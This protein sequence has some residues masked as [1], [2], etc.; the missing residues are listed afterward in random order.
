M[1]PILVRNA[2]DVSGPLSRISASPHARPLQQHTAYHQ[3]FVLQFLRV[4]HMLG[5]MTQLG[6]LR[7][8][9]QVLDR[10]HPRA[11]AHMPRMSG[12]SADQGLHNARGYEFVSGVVVF[13]DHVVV[14]HG[15]I[16]PM[17]EQL[18]QVT[19]ATFCAGVV[20]KN[21]I[22]VEA[23]PKLSD[24][25]GEYIGAASW[26]WGLMGFRAEVVKPQTPSQ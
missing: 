10:D 11:H 25:L 26:K 17:M 21:G 6:P 8:D 12:V 4:V 2:L 3:D 15:K 19:G 14:A 22:I 1:R 24:F 9:P 20:V 13:N 16:H 5:V 7:R 23:A 18:I